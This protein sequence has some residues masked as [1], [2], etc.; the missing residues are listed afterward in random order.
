ML[1]M[2]EKFLS[3]SLMQIKNYLTPFLPQESKRPPSK[4]FQ[5]KDIP[6]PP[7]VTRFRRRSSPRLTGKK[8]TTYREE[9]EEAAELE[10]KRSNFDNLQMLIDLIK[11]DK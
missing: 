1:N 7:Y 10:D 11:R 2:L 5:S 6:T 8:R 4:T 3:P 9:Q